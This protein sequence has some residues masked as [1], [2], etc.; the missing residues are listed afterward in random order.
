MATPSVSP[1]ELT[2]E[3]VVL[4]VPTDADVDRIAELCVDPA[5]AE[6]T[7]VPSPYTRDDAVSFVNGFVA[8]GWASGRIHTWGIRADGA[9]VGMIGLNG[10]E[11]SAAEIGFWLAPEARGRGLMSEATALALDYGFAPAPE[12]LGLQRIVWHAFAGNA[13]SAAVARRAGF[14]FEGVSRLGAVHRGRRRDDWQAGLLATDPREPADGWP[15][16]TGA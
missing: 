13:A 8:D 6:W 5:I 10:V 9:L 7:T 16:E 11:D 3:R 4:S 15:A 12:G 1:V 2:G 14:T